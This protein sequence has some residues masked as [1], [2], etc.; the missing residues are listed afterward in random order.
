MS[1]Q[2]IK[3]I[4]P[5]VIV[6]VAFSITTTPASADT[7]PGKQWAFVTPHKTQ[8]LQIPGTTNPID[9]FFLAKLRAKGLDLAP[10]ADRTT[11]L[12]R[13]SF[14]LT[15]LP[16]KPELLN[17]SYGRSLD[18]LLASPQYGERWGRRWLDVVRYGETDGGEHNYLRS[19][20]WPY[21][22]YVIEALNQDLPF[23]AFVR[24]QIAGDILYP[25]DRKKLAATGFLVSGPWDQV[26]VVLNKDPIM[27]K[28]ARMDELDDLVT[29]TCSTFLGLTVNC[30]RC[31]DHKFDPIPSRDYYRLTAAFSGAGFGER[32]VATPEEQSSY[33]KQTKPL[34][35]E[36]NRIETT[37]RA[38]ADPIVT[39]TLLAKYRKLEDERKGETQRNM[40]NPVFNRE[41]FTP[42]EARWFRLVIKQNEGARPRIDKLVLLPAGHIV[43]TWRGSADSGE[44][45]PVILNIEMPVERRVDTIEW[46]TNLETGDR[47]GTP[48]IY[49]FEA[50]RDGKMWRKVASSLDHIG[51]NE[52]DLPT[53]VEAEIA[54][55]LTPEQRE[56]RRRLADRSS[57]LQRMLD[58]VATPPK[59]YACN[60]RDP[61]K[62][63]LLERG[64]VQKPLEEVKPG[65]LMSVAQLTPVFDL[66][67]DATD[68]QR[69]L[70]LANWIADDRNPLTARVIVNRIWFGHFGAGLVNTPSDFGN[71]GERPS[72]PELLDWL[73][74]SFME[75]GWSQKWLHRLILT[76]RTYQ[77]SAQ[78]NAKAHAVDAGNRLLWHMPLKRMDA[79]TL[80]DTIL[81]VSRRLDMK[82]GGPSFALHTQGGRGSF[83]YH[84]LDNDGPEVWRRA[85]YRLVVRGGDKTMLDTFDCPD[86]SV[87][88]PIRQ[89]SNT[90]V[91]ALTLMNNSFVIKQADLLALRLTAE[92]TSS[93][94]Q[95]RLA[96]NLLF[97]RPPTSNEVD[98][99]QRF[100]TKH[101]LSLYCRALLN[102]NEFVYVP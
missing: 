90:P 99:A 43:E 33:D 76:S 23:N 16:P 72:H 57:T 65:A 78:F 15:G 55:T 73:A 35:S 67:A 10:P 20:S 2:H 100:L 50:S 79:E 93:R 83:I 92:A 1:N 47:D 95:V 11:L 48:S 28:T 45:H 9:A 40:I 85:V 24:E 81:A 5:F 66:P 42:I 26:S 62:S 37:L 84:T 36:L 68:K 88:T 94:E 53:V 96:F 61:E 29:T 6:L 74:V 41:S 21:R 12:R 44:S 82:M 75:H 39:R 30:A 46:S 89:I 52:Q 98:N 25:G 38:T 27:K 71:M 31:H 49:Q 14:D 59:L 64:S 4:T 58:A 13:L 91:Q 3:S 77:Q 86:P 17:E 51:R 22:D 18:R 80:R 60:S 56:E 34:R 69:R 87:A 97:S 70:A 8:P 54:A 32:S 101:S 19:N 102:S 63:F 7:P